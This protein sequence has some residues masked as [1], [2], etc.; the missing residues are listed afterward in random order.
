VFSCFRGLPL[1]CA[2]L[3]AS[4]GARLMT[5][6][7][8]PG[9]PAADAADAI[10]DATAAC[11]NVSTFSAEIGVSGSIGGQRL[12]GRLLVGLASPAS[13]RIEA[14]APVGAPVF[15]F[16]AS[17]QDAT[18]LLPRD[19]RVLEHGPAG[20]V[21]EAVAGVPLDPA[22]LKAALTGCAQA[23][24]P[25][26][27]RS[28]GDDWRVVPDGPTSLYLHRDRKTR[29][30]QVAAAVRRGGGA[31][32]S[33]SSGPSPPQSTGEW[34]AEYRDVRDGLPRSVHFAGGQRIDLNLS[35]SQVSLNEPLGAEVFRVEIPPSAEPIT[36]DELRHARPGVRE[37]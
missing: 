27:G 2:L 33:A 15:I 24:D 32:P 37:N 8:G 14:V 31:S 20:S 26:H 34:R 11:R 16:V 29:R 36:L 22:D 4:C 21:L 1:M 23:P 6:P 28:L 13:A 9:A 10:A 19:N 30:W 17:G 18:V 35:L 5:L 7:A 12:R 3:C 25:A